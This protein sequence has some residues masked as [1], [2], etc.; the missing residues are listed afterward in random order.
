MTGMKLVARLQAVRLEKERV[1]LS[2]LA[3]SFF[4]VFYS[5]AAI[6]SPVAWRLAF[7]AL[8]FCYGV[9][10]MALACQWFWARWYAS[11][12]AWSG[13]VVGLASLVM[14][15]WHPVLAVY[16]G[17]HALVLI[18]LAGPNMAARFEMQREWRERF[19]MDEFGVARLRRMVTRASAALPSLI[20]WVLAPRE[21]Q[22]GWFVAGVAMLSALTGL[23]GTLFLRTWGVLAIGT[24]G[25]LTL[26]GLGFSS[27]ISPDASAWI[28]SLGQAESV[29]WGALLS[30]ILLLAAVLPLARAIRCAWRTLD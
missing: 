2:L 26:V 25:L 27:P 6:S 24:S 5:L 22:G 18:M 11:G 23:T 29:W 30:A 17:L 28:G 16:G 13:T 1:A 9:G 14:V 10:F 8:A 15:G 4:V 3:L 20:L 21:G 19:A 7:L 12:L